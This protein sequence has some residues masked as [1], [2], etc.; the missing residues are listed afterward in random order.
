[1]KLCVQCKILKSNE[2]FSWRS[3]SK[4]TRQPRCK[5]CTSIYNKQF[6]EI[7][8]K[9]RQE[10]RKCLTCGVQLSTENSASKSSKYC[11]QHKPTPQE[12]AAKSNDSR[13]EKLKAKWGSKEERE[14]RKREHNRKYHAARL[15]NS[16]QAL[17]AHR[18]RN[19]INCAL[20]QYAVTLKGETTKNLGCS[21]AELKVRFES[22]FYPNPETGEPM[23]WDN[24]SQWDIDHIRPL[25]SF[26]LT[27]HEQL[28]IAC[29]Y[30]NLQPLWKADNI[31][32]SNSI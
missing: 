21:F 6:A 23:T 3:I 30:K 1:M 15:K 7:K 19:R 14:Q 22:M 29:N 32:K 12:V 31:S 17:I 27:D 18:L 8:S 24:Y 25:S 26:D 4:Q 11:S 13:I 28:K 10:R 5:P 9:Y 20:R 2:D 16:P